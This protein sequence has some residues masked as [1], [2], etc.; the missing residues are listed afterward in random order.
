MYKIGKF[1][2]HKPERVNIMERKPTNE[3]TMKTV[4][5]VYAVAVLLAIG[6]AAFA[7]YSTEKALKGALVEEASESR[8]L[9]SLPYE[10]TKE[11]KSGDGQVL[12]DVTN[13]P[14]TRKEVA[15]QNEIKKEETTTEEE[16]TNMFAEP[17]SEQFIMPVKGDVIKGFSG[18]TPVYSKTMNDWR[19]HTGVDIKADDGEQVRAAA[20]GTVTAVDTD[21]LYGTSV[22]VDHGNSLIM[23]YCGLDRE[24][25]PVKVGTVLES[26]DAVGYVLSVPCESEDGTHLHL[27]ATLDG[28][29]KDPLEIMGKK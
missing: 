2:N 10:T 26:G 14:D 11:T 16:T 28:D 5:I 7:K 22:T 1:V 17:F 9:L 4:K 24:S 8:A 20:Y 29:L 18:G 27:E 13:V 23:T 25:L 15:L 3:K 21:A 12:G 6:G 19:A